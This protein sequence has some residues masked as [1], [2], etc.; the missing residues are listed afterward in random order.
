MSEVRKTTFWHAQQLPALALSATLKRNKTNNFDKALR[1]CRA[2]GSGELE[3]RADVACVVCARKEWL[4]ERYKVHLW[5]PFEKQ[6]TLSEAAR[7]MGNQDQEGSPQ[8]EDEDDAQK[9]DEDAAGEA[10]GGNYDGP[11]LVEGMTLA[12]IRQDLLLRGVDVSEDGVGARGGLTFV[13]CDGVAT[14]W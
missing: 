6:Q 8:G 7:A 11:E 13:P 9:E 14:V 1:C 2:G 5:K 10:G 12:W 3:I 4:D